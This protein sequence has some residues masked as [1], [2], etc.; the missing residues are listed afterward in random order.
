MKICIFG[1]GAIGGYMGA[2]LAQAGA[3]VSLVARGPHLAAM[4]EKGLTLIEE[5]LVIERAFDTGYPLQTVYY[6]NACL[7]TDGESLLLR[8]QAAAEREPERAGMEFVEVT[9][10]V[11]GKISYRD[12]P[13][14]LLVVAPQARL[15]LDELELDDRPGREPLLITQL[16]PAKIDDAVL[17]RGLNPLAAPSPLAL[18][19]RRDDAERQMQ[20]G[21]AVPD[22]SARHHR[23]AVEVTG[24]R[25][26]PAGTLRDVLVDLAVL[27]LARAEALDGGHDHARVE[28][29]DPLPAEAH[30]VER[31]RAK[32]LDQGVGRLRQAADEEPVQRQSAGAPH[33]QPSQQGGPE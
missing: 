3:E 7:D 23:H 10:P 31:A 1:A 26:R 9:E 33:H 32:V 11:M 15:T 21:S 29:L 24:R 6:C 30:P 22:L 18:E 25:R 17:H 27:V 16:D 19:E 28:F 13:A 2:K 5:P 4:R 20:A 12:R 14:G 8:L